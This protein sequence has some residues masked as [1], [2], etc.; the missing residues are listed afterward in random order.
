[1][2]MNWPVSIHKHR[3]LLQF[4]PQEFL[5]SACYSFKKGQLEGAQKNSY[6][7]I[8][9]AALIGQPTLPCDRQ[10]GNAA[11]EGLICIHI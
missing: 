11:S 10:L 2:A 9:L 4:N 3:K 1:M 8:T 5:E 7:V 6:A